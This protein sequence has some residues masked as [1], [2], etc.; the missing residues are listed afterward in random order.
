MV[1]KATEQE[2]QQARKTWALATITYEDF[3]VA[4][5]VATR[6]VVNKKVA[7]E[8]RRL[9]KG[10]VPAGLYEHWKSKEGAAKFYVVDHVNFEVNVHYPTVSYASLY[11]ELAGEFDS[12]HLH[13]KEHPEVQAFE[14]EDYGF[15]T[16]IDRLDDPEYPYRGPRFRLVEKLSPKEIAV[17][18]DY[19]GELSAIKRTDKFL[20][21]VGK[22]IKRPLV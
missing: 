18:L 8:C 13:H 11:G 20:L 16:P 1:V 7:M 9:L 17:L 4:A 3:V 15:L 14:K 6:Q 12:R 21:R 2:F 5:T 22:A 19:V 10:L